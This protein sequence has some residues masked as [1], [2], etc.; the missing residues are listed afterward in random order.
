MRISEAATVMG[1]ENAWASAKERSRKR[2][3]RTGS[4]SARA[5]A[6][7]TWWAVKY[8]CSKTKQKA[9]MPSVPFGFG[10]GET[11]LSLTFETRAACCRFPEWSLLHAKP[12]CSHALER[13]A[14]TSD[15]GGRN[16]P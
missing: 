2:Q 12:V 9:L 5:S 10:Q 4:N 16:A 13:T 6:K 8:T 15:G 3:K 1:R 7:R 11:F 14:L